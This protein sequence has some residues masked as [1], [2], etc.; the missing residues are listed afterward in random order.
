M[1]KATNRHLYFVNAPTDIFFIG[2]ASFLLYFGLM[3]FYSDIRTPE[4]I[5]AGVILSWLINWP[6]FSMSTYRLY[7]NKANIRRYPFTAYAIPIIVFCGV[8]LSFKYP[9]IVAPIFIKL[10]MIWSPY[11]FAGQTI[12]ITFVYAMRAGIN[13]TT[14]E[15]KVFA[16][17]IFLTFFVSTIRAEVSREGYSFYSIKYP[18][19][20]VPQWIA[21]IA[22]YGLWLSLFALAILVVRWS[23]KNKQFLP[24]IVI[25]PAATQY[26]WFIQSVYK[27]SFQEFVPMLH[28]LQYIIIA[29][30]LQLKEKIDIKKI[31]P[32]RKYVVWETARWL[33]INFVGGVILFFMLPKIGSLLNFSAFFSIAVVFAAVQIHH[34][35]VDGVIWKLR[36]SAVA[37]PLTMTLGDLTGKNKEPYQS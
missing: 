37:H 27:P 25:L 36:N 7:Q 6:H 19:F 33:S 13:L 32:S 14:L 3:F 35:F 4:I 17:F 16:Y 31:T 24:L 22:E 21:D 1:K 15:K 26:L 12:G 10:F 9:L 8:I 23:Y 18:S 30:G 2:G 34:F 28:S 29:W 11:H 20:A 5:T